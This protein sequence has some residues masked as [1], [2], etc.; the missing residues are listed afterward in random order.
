MIMS[1]NHIED[2]VP[3]SAQ[4]QHTA[5]SSM[6]KRVFQDTD[7]ANAEQRSLRRPDPPDVTQQTAHPSSLFKDLP[8]PTVIQRKTFFDLP[9][10]IRQQIYGLAFQRNFS[11]TRKFYPFKYIE[12]ISDH[13]LPMALLLA[14]R[15]VHAETLQYYLDTVYTRLY[16]VKPCIFTGPE[17]SLILLATN[18]KRWCLHLNHSWHDSPDDIQYPILHSIFQILAWGAHTIRTVVIQIPC[19]CSKP[20]TTMKDCYTL[21]MWK[22]TFF[23]LFTRL[24]DIRLNGAVHIVPTRKPAFPPCPLRKCKALATLFETTQKP[25]TQGSFHGIH[26]SCP[27]FK[28]DKITFNEITRAR[29]H[30]GSVRQLGC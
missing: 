27:K 7:P 8:L 29:G 17:T 30:N 25:S 9:L 26:Q 14:N 4:V 10:E 15:D 18:V 5:L 19:L 21:H 11:P 22:D 20:G 12:V 16:I 2:Q 24:S 28:A 1:K 3:P 23:P 13:R 6:V